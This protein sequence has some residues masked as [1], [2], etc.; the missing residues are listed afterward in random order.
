VCLLNAVGAASRAALPVRPGT[1]QG[2]WVAP[3]LLW[4]FAALA[5]VAGGLFTKWTAPAF[6]YL[7]VV[8]FLALQGRLKL[9]LSPAHLAGAGLVAALAVGWL[10]L[11]GHVAGW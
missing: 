5:C 1:Q 6:F 10:A 3:D 2:C 8:P 9:L 4:W 7:T 11:A